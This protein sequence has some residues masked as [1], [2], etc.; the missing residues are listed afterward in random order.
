MRASVRDDP[1]CI[2]EALAVI[3]AEKAQAKS[4]SDRQ[5]IFQVI[6]E[7]E[8]WIKGV[9]CLSTQTGCQ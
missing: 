8:G 9:V 1:D 2:S 5:L 3:E 6:R 4:E 7:S